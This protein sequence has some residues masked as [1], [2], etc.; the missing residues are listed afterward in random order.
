[1]VKNKF[2]PNCGRK[3]LVRY[4]SMPTVF[5][6]SVCQQAFAITPRF[7]QSGPWEATM[8]TVNKQGTT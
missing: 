4:P 8:N 3:I 1:M 7:H 2:C 6:C 5:W